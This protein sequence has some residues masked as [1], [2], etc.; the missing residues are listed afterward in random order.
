MI[1]PYCESNELR[2][3][4][5]RTTDKLTIRR[6]RLCEK[7]NKRFTTYERI[8]VDPIIVVKQNSERE[9]YNKE[10]IKASIIAVCHKRPIFDV[11]IEKITDIINNEILKTT[12]KEINSENIRKIVLQ[13]LI[14]LDKIAYDRYLS[15][16]EN[17]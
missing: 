4:D 7:C 17:N 11:E 1:C 5:S 8:E 12:E 10:K 6:R 15:A 13:N 2:V 16:Y 3:I 14:N 9:P